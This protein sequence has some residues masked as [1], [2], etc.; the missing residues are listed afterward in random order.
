MQ[1]INPMKL[2]IACTLFCLAAQA[3]TDEAIL[4][5]TYAEQYRYCDSV[6]AHLTKLDS[7][8][9]VKKVDQ[10]LI[11]SEQK[12]DMPLHYGLQIAKS[13]Y[14]LWHFRQDAAE[15]ELLKLISILKEEELTY[16]EAEAMG[17]LAHYYWVKRAYSPALEHSIRSHSLYSKFTAE[18]FPLKTDYL[19][20]YG[21]KYYH[22]GDYA[23][24]IKY[25]QEGWQSLKD[26]SHPGVITLLNSLGLA[27]LHNDRLDS[28]E[29]FL[30]KAYM[31]ALDKKDD[32]W[33]AILL[34]NL[35]KIYYL[36]GNYDD[37]I[38]CLQTDVERCRKTEPVNAAYSLALLSQ[39]WLEKGEKEK[40]LQ[41]IL[42]A[43]ALI[44]QE[45]RYK[46]YT[47][48]QRIYPVLAK[49]Y[50]MHGNSALAYAYM[51]S[52][53]VAKDSV[54]K[55][56]NMLLLTGAHYK[57]EASKH[58]EEMERQE[59]ERKRQRWLTNVM[60]GGFVM[61]LLIAIFF[62]RSERIKYV[63]AKQK[64]INEK[65]FA[66][67]ELSTA[68][69][70]L[71][72]FR[73]SISDKNDMIEKFTSQ[74]HRMR[75]QGALEG[76]AENE[77]LMN[78]QQST[79][80][81]DSQWKNFQALFENVHKDFLQRMHA[82]VPGLTPIETRF[83]LL[84]KLRMSKKEM[85]SVLGIST[86]AVQLNKERLRQKLRLPQAEFSLEDFADSI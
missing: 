72:E 76:E 35:G 43:N 75:R 1:N 18:E 10:L 41:S 44:K 5:K 33:P 30:N 45:E 73:Q 38:P 51:D 27:Y 80:L 26:I 54:A 78:L 47:V 15:Q 29:Y 21:G 17:E 6:Y 68:S 22:F 82:K 34:G 11:W 67:A 59:Q 71:D 37:A 65:K 53:S 13:K 2:F 74:L 46:E 86:D 63:Q 81:T 70:R 61:F 62:I 25:F 9:A 7:T 16:L 32:I 31:I 12:G 23:T 4:F 40:A 84:S 52:A 69:A 36:K 58:I 28:A 66:E 39:I 8:A 64:L 49:V 14:L 20:A 79:I 77:E 48:Q 42:E 19:F 55:Q 50:A 57:V 56:T 60:A 24:A 85:A 3:S 83:M